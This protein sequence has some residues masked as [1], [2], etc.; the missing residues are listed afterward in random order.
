LNNGLHR[1]ENHYEYL[2]SSIETI[3]VGG[4]DPYEP[5]SPLRPPFLRNGGLG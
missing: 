1:N 2:Y 4:Y 3:T 5:T